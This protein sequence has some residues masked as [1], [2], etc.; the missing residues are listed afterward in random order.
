MT[1]EKET[2]VEEVVNATMI[3]D[4]E[5]KLNVPDK[6]GPRRVKKY[7]SGAADVRTS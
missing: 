4:E 1:T 3:V 6:K 5:A 7:G 2:K